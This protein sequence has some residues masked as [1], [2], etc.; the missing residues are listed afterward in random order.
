MAKFEC[1]AN[2]LAAYQEFE[3]LGGIEGID[4]F[5]EAQYWENE[6]PIHDEDG[7]IAYEAMMDAWAKSENCPE[8]AQ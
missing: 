3:R 1:L 2:T 8:W 4:A 6:G 7:E 5:Y